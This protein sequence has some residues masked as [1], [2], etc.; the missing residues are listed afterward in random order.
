MIPQA[1]FEEGI[2]HCEINAFTAFREADKSLSQ[3]DFRQAYL[4]GILA[5]EETGKAGFLLEKMGQHQITI[6]EWGDR[7]TFL[8]HTAKIEKAKDIH[9]QDL[10]D[11]FEK[12]FPAL[13]GIKPEI[14]GW[15]EKE[16]KELWI[17]R[18]K[19]L[20]VDYNFE[21]GEWASPQDIPDLEDRARVVLEKAQSAFLALEGQVE[22]VGITPE[23]RRITM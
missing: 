13:R 4:F 9:R 10:V 17:Y 11:F 7:A 18:N 20:F 8:S 3:G 14:I 15:S 5:L 6:N 2:K 1:R 19:V 22:N 16:L 12:E 21:K 23:L